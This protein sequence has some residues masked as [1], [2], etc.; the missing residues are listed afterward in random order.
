MST[1]RCYFLTSDLQIGRAEEI[2]ADD[3]SCAIA[4]ARVALSAERQCRAFELWLADQRVG[5]E[6]P[7]GA[8]PLGHLLPLAS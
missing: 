8:E 5:S 1:Y 7:E 6:F 4:T 3:D 2:E